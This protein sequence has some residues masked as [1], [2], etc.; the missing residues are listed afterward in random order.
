MSRCRASIVGSP[1]VDPAQS[2]QHPTDTQRSW[3]AWVRERLATSWAR[4]LSAASRP[5]ATG[6][7]T[8]G[9]PPKP[10]RRNIAGIGGVKDLTTQRR[11]GIYPQPQ[12]N[13]TYL[14]DS[15]VQHTTVLIAQVATTAGMRA[16]LSHVAGQVFLDLVKE[17]ERQGVTRRVAADMFGLALRS[18]QQKRQRLA[19]SSTDPGKTLWEAVYQFLQAQEVA[20]R[21]EILRR[22]RKDDDTLIKSLLSDL[23]DSGLVYRTGTR[24]AAVFRVA[25]E[26]DVRRSHDSTRA[27]Q[28]AVW[29][30]IYREGPMTRQA[31]LGTASASEQQ[32]DQ[33]LVVLTADGRVR[34]HEAG[35]QVVYDS[36]ECFL[37]MDDDAAWA[38]NVINH[39]QMMTSAICAKLANGK[40]RAVPDEELGGSSYSFHVWPGH[41]G[42]TRARQLLASTRQSVG[43]LWDEIAQ[44]NRE[45]GLPTDGVTR[46]NFYFGQSLTAQ[47]LES[48]TTDP[49]GES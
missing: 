9:V 22:F 14:I 16:P 26:E 34:L 24:Q 19:E 11:A 35:T 2:T 30:R 41:P 49:E 33:A 29:F 15:I 28:A 13:V 42:E 23:V 46:V 18:Y 44:Y 48:I 12:M 4:N 10:T 45:H 21:G 8:P 3:S 6:G 5:S 32:L 31:L 38:A 7:A 36:R 25:P 27:L 37:P 40:T 1:G 17:L 43:Q 20:T 39:F 47:S